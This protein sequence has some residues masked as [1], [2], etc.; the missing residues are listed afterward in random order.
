MKKFKNKF[1]FFII[2]ILIVTPF[3]VKKIANFQNKQDFSK[4]T[5]F[6]DENN[7][8]FIYKQKFENKTAV[9]NREFSKNGFDYIYQISKIN[10]N[11][12]FVG[13]K[14]NKGYATLLDKNGLEIHQFNFRS[15]G[16][17]YGCLMSDFLILGGDNE[18]FL[19]DRKTYKKIKKFENFDKAICYDDF[20]I[21]TDK[22][23]RLYKISQNG[24]IIWDKKVTKK[25]NFETVYTYYA[26]SDSPR[27]NRIIK[28]EIS[29]L[30]KLTKNSFLIVLNYKNLLEMNFDGNVRSEQ[31][32]NYSFEDAM[33]IDSDLFI[34]ASNNDKLY[35]LKNTKLQNKLFED[36]IFSSHLAKFKDGFI[37]ATMSKNGDRNTLFVIY[38]NKNGKL[39][40]KTILDDEVSHK[41]N[42]NIFSMQNE[43]FLTGNLTY[44]IKL[45]PQKIKDKII[46]FKEYK[47]EAFIFKIDENF[48]INSEN[49]NKFP[50]DNLLNL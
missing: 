40:N 35:L 6:V 49:S 37:T 42:L 45:P 13:E 27:Q 15:H 30:K 5:T 48:L 26:N 20:L 39:I 8:E 22:K 24:K 12:L 44:T 10:N 23:N 7:S 4:N 36:F 3:L 50:K 41:Q 29:Y 34:L 16:R 2:L 43:A 11:Y 14:E 18:A 32:I 46:S 47:S 31:N 38:F 33:K 1:I 19:I 17:S 21:A 25:D 9:W 28:N